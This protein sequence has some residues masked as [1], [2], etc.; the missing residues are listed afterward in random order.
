MPDITSMVCRARRS[1]RRRLALICRRMLI[2]SIQA[3]LDGDYV[4]AIHIF[5]PRI[6][7]ALR[8]LLGL[9]GLPT[10]KPMLLLKRRHAGKEPE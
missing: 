6:E 4:K 10:I 1:I 3:Y 9:L 7:A 5:V 2:R 8:E